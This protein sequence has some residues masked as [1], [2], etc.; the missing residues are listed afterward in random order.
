[1]RKYLRMSAAFICLGSACA[2]QANAQISEPAGAAAQPC[3]MPKKGVGE[4]KWNR[5]ELGMISV[6]L[7]ETLL[8]RRTDRCGEKCYIFENE[9]MYFDA[10]LTQSAWRPTFEKKYPTFVAE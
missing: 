1:M 8:R 10:D 4:S 6:C 7:P 5:H 9:E 2:W 3:P